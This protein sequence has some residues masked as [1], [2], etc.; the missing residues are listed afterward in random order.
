MLH[1]NQLKQQY[2]HQF[3]INAELEDFFEDSSFLIWVTF[4][5]EKSNILIFEDPNVF[6]DPKTGEKD[7]WVFSLAEWGGQ[8]IN[9]YEQF[10]SKEAAY[11]AAYNF[12]KEHGTPKPK[13]IPANQISLF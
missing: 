10:P 9:Y 2:W 5:G 8:Q 7:A 6:E 12:W 11:E 4:K 1:P 3:S 13:P